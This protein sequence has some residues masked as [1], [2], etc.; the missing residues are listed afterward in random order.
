VS[1]ALAR[2][3]A[4]CLEK[5][6]TRR[7]QTARDLAFAL[8]T[9]GSLRH[10]RSEMLEDSASP[11][12]WPAWQWVAVVAGAS[13]LLVA[14]FFIRGLIGPAER[15]VDEI[16]AHRL[17]DARALKSFQPFRRTAGRWPLSRMSPDT[18]KL[19]CGSLAV[20]PRCKSRAIPPT[21]YILGGRLILRPFSITATVRYLAVSDRSVADGQRP[22]WNQAD[23]TDQCRPRTLSRAG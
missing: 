10:Q 6:P 19:S 2:V 5:Q 20:E 17:T 11:R 12:R 22:W 13:A 4:H 8:E 14:G 15:V 7:F 3:V 18:H 16:R 9:I 1:P 21:I 23:R